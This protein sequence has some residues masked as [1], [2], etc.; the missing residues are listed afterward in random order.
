MR[1]GESRK[2]EAF[3]GTVSATVT[4]KSPGATVTRPF[5]PTVLKLHRTL[6]AGPLCVQS[7]TRLGDCLHNVKEKCKTQEEGKCLFW[8]GLSL[9]SKVSDHVLQQSPDLWQ[10]FREM[11]QRWCKLWRKK[12][13]IGVLR[14]WAEP[15]WTWQGRTLRVWRIANAALKGSSREEGQMPLSHNNNQSFHLLSAYC[16]PG[17]LC[18]LSL[19]LTAGTMNYPFLI[20]KDEKTHSE[21]LSKTLTNTPSSRARFLCPWDFPDKNTEMGCHDLL[22]GIFPTQGLNP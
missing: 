9:A 13:I 18:A 4:M 2:L 6:G 8:K 17:A 20:C 7:A 5:P 22:Q 12:K 3:G 16:V 21:K 14:K 19:I 10:G 11:R 15:C 1:P